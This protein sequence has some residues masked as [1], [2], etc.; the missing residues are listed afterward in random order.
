MSVQAITIDAIFERGVLHPVQ[1]LPLTE[2]QR[3]RVT[4]Q[5]PPL[6]AGWP[7]DVAAIYEEIAEEDRRLAAAMW[8]TVKETWPQGGELS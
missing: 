8:N 4:V 2:N 6:Q 3:V 1:P 7:A 5:M